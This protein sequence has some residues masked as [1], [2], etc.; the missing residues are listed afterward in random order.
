MRACTNCTLWDAVT[1]QHRQRIL[2]QRT[3]LGAEAMLYNIRHQY[4]C[5]TAVYVPCCN[6]WLFH[7]KHVHRVSWRTLT[8]TEL[9]SLSKKTFRGLMSKEEDFQL[10]IAQ[11]DRGQTLYGLGSVTD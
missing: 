9:L 11:Y 4:H 1:L 10:S 5:P 6:V 7:C 8:H 3:V 2:E